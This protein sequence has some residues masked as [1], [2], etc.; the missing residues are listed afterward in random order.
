[1]KRPILIAL[2]LLAS[3]RLLADN[4]AKGTFETFVDGRPRLAWELLKGYRLFFHPDD[5]EPMRRSLTLAIPTE[6]KVISAYSLVRP[7]EPN[8]DFKDA[9]LRIEG[10][11]KE[12][13][14]LF[15]W[16]GEYQG[17]DFPD[18]K[19]YYEIHVRWADGDSLNQ[20]VVILKSLD[21]PKLI[22]VG[23]QK[24]EEHPLE[25]KKGEFRAVNVAAS[26]S[27]KEMPQ[28]AVIARVLAPSLDGAFE[29]EGIQLSY[30]YVEDEEGNPAPKANDWICGCQQPLPADSPAR[31][32]AKKVRCDWDVSDLSPGIYELR[33]SLYHK[34][35]HPGQFDPCDTPILD[36]DRIRVLVR[37]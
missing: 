34:M 11:L 7:L 16:D 35:K 12:D 3:A 32:T 27:K 5:P 6:R 23:Q 33:L 20:T 18:Q 28:V 30:K 26:F 10:E 36:E 4:S 9:W 15:T 25:F 14:I 21:H 29:T 8:K 19:Y 2:A 31:L 1:M 17:A 22:Q 24:L 37:P 13:R